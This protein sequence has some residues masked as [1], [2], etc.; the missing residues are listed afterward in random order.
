[1]WSLV[2]HPRACRALC[3]Y[4]RRRAATDRAT[5]NLQGSRAT[6]ISAGDSKLKAARFVKTK[7]STKNF[8]ESGAD[9]ATEVAGCKGYVTNIAVTV[10]STNES[11]VSIATCGL[12]SSLFGYRRPISSP[13]GLRA[14]RRSSRGA[15]DGRFHSF[16]SRE[17]HEG[18]DGMSL[19]KVATALSALCEFVGEIDGHKLMFPPDTTLAAAV[20][21][22]RLVAF[23]LG[24][25][26]NC[27]NPAGH[28]VQASRP[29][30]L[31]RWVM[32]RRIV[33]ISL[34]KRLVERNV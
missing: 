28:E 25:T 12:F 1:M 34:G 11:S 4:R 17:V 8:D 3:Q 29:V 31:I 26:V 6:R 27:T 33:V 13:S 5:L 20:L 2:E 21:V 10:M 23:A 19:K 18:C 15:F 24:G 32:S 14:H 30:G 7:G 9:K 22:K 16:D